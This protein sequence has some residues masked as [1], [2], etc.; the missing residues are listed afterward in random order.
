MSILEPMDEDTVV[1]EDKPALTVL[2]MM[3]V[4]SKEVTVLEMAEITGDVMGVVTKDNDVA[5]VGVDISEVEPSLMVVAVEI[6]VII[7][8]MVVEV[9]DKDDV[10]VTA[11]GEDDKD[12]MIT[13]DVTGACISLTPPWSETTRMCCFL[14]FFS[15]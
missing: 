10:V 4:I 3:D 2:G 15:W 9:V 12:L 8:N 13:D 14:A 6:A 7:G 11:V 1:G 5:M